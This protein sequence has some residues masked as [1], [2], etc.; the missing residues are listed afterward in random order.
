MQRAQPAQYQETIFGSRQHRHLIVGFAQFR[1]PLFIGGNQ[2]HQHIGMAAGIFGSGFKGDIAAVF[3]STEKERCRPGIINNS[4]NMMTFSH[5]LHL[6]G[7]GAGGF[8]ENYSCFRADEGFNPRAD[9][10]VIIGGGNSHFRQ[11]TAA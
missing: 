11:Q 7:L 4:R 5:R 1:P 8:K 6:K 3:M 9:Q 10:R 2:S